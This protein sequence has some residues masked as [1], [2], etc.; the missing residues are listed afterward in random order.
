M[1]TNFHIVADPLCAHHGPHFGKL[2][3]KLYGVFI[4]L[5]NLRWPLNVMIIIY[6][7][8]CKATKSEFHQVP[9]EL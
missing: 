3:F 6:I 7:F 9:F 4:K 5:L 8:A 1:L 2:W